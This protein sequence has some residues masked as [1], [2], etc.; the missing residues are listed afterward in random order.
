MNK[1][2]LTYKEWMEEIDNLLFTKIGL[3]QADLADWLSRDAYENGDTIQD[4]ARECLEA[5]DLI[6]EDLIDEL[7]S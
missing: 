6:D 5:Q 7:V 4:G 3:A 2:Y 1:S